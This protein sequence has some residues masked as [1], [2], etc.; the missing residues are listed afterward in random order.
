MVYNIF[1]KKS[2]GSGVNT[3]ANNEKIAEE[4]DKPIIKKKI[5]KIFFL[6]LK[7]IFRVLI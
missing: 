5:K 6:N 1:D 7:T 3:N 2:A 4:L